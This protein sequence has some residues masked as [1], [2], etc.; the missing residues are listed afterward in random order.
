MNQKNECSINCIEEMKKK[1][2][3]ELEFQYVSE[4]VNEERILKELKSLYIKNVFNSM[5]SCLRDIYDIQYAL[6]QR[7]KKEYAVKYGR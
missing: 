5:G 6:V 3:I 1:F 2:Y 4:I 7:L